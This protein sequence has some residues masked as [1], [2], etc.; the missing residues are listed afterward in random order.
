MLTPTRALRQ[1]FR[2]LGCSTVHYLLERSRVVEQA[3]RERNFHVLYQLCAGGVSDVP[4]RH[5]LGLRPHHTFRLLNPALQG[6]AAK[7]KDSVARGTG[8][9]GDA[10]GTGADKSPSS[11]RP[12]RGWALQLT[13][14]GAVVSESGGAAAIDGVDDAAEW[15]R[16]VAALA[17]MCGTA[18]DPR[19]DEGGALW[20]VLAAVLHLG[21]VSVGVDEHECASIPSPPLA[22]CADA[23]VSAR[24]VDIDGMGPGK[25]PLRTAARLLGVD[26]DALC[27]ALVTRTFASGRGS[28]ATIPLSPAQVCRVE[29][30][31]PHSCLEAAL[32]KLAPCSRLCLCAC[33]MWAFVCPLGCSCARPMGASVRW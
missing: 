32:A 19:G 17:C 24:D 14:G 21:D 18:E 13:S 7:L 11:E 22:G 6:T 5:R 9:G 26:R 15:Q 3:S 20:D 23:P 10:G 25:D 12:S 1:Q 2:V 16:T 4:L 31:A 29:P 30:A 27:A 8:A 28:A 33:S